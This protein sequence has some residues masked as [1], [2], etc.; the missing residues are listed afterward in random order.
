MKRWDYAVLALS[1]FTG[2]N[3]H[4]DLER[5]LIE[6]GKIGWRVIGNTEHLAILEREYTEG[7]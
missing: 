7:Q 1:Q 5:V 3:Y 6:A 4:K 2:E